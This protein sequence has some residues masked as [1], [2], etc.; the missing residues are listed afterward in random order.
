[1]NK[2]EIS[3]VK[4]GIQEA[5]PKILFPTHLQIS[6]P[7]PKQEIKDCLS[8]LVGK[9]I[10]LKEYDD[11]ASWLGNNHGKGLLCIGNCGRGKTMLCYRIIP[12]LLNHFM[13][14]CVCCYDALDINTQIDEM[15]TKYLISVDDIGIESDYIHYGVRRQPFAELVDVAEK[16]GCLL[17]LTTN[18]TTDELLVK[19]GVRVIDRLKRITKVVHFIGDSLR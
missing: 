6:I 10:W 16:K 18:L 14:K 9:P 13:R 17:L 3:R 12:I 8:T 15:K 1:M 19:Y 2:E 11:I 4:A 5:N 7:N